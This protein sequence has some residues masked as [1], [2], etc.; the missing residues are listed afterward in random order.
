LNIQHRIAQSLEGA[1][2]QHPR[3]LRSIVHLV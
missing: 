3:T 2:L 1:D